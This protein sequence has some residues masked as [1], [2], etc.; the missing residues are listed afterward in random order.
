[1]LGNQ[2]V[3]H[4]RHVLE[5]AHVLEGTYHALARNFMARQTFDGLA[6][7]HDAAG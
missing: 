3:F 7:E 2:Q 4:R 1:M 6:I 5:Q